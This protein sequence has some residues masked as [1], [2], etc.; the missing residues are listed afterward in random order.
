LRIHSAPTVYSTDSC[1][2]ASYTWI[3]K[4]TKVRAEMSRERSRGELRGEE[5]GGDNRRKEQKRVEEVRGQWRTH[6]RVE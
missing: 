4:G 2:C 5:K 6:R 1:A 3:R